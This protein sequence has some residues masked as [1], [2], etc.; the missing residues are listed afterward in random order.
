M[1][2]LVGLV[3]SLHRPR[4][5]GRW[6][7][8]W[9]IGAAGPPPP[10]P[11]CASSDPAAVAPRHLHASLALPYRPPICFADSAASAL[12]HGYRRRWPPPAVCPSR[13]PYVA[14]RP[15]HPAAVSIPSAGPS[16]RACMPLHPDPR[17]RRLPPAAVLGT[18]AR[19][20]PCRSPNVSPRQ[21]HAFRG[22]Y[23]HVR[24]PRVP[25]RRPMRFI[26]RR[27]IRYRFVCVVCVTRY[28]PAASPRR[29]VDRHDVPEVAHATRVHHILY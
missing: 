24:I 15:P 16:G 5:R 18:A 12:S 2:S 11:S 26:K 28:I 6:R 23:H 9:G 7:L 14:R 8:G 25:R 20:H 1:Q 22:A 3:Y 19:A 13:A 4:V 29:A 21:P 10:H 27:R 17:Q